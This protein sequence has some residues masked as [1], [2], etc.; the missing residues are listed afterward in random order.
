MDSEIVSED[1]GNDHFKLLYIF[2]IKFEAHD[3][4]EASRCKDTENS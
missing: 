1:L 4:A 3:N 2:N